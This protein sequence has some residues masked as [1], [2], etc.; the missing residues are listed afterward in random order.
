[1]RGSGVIPPVIGWGLVVL[2]HVSATIPSCVAQC[3]FVPAH[4][5]DV[6]RNLPSPLSNSGLPLATVQSLKFCMIVVCEFSLVFVLV[7]FIESVGD[8]SNAGCFKLAASLPWFGRC[9]SC[10]PA[11]L[12]AAAT[13]CAPPHWLNGTS[14]FATISFA[15]AS[16]IV[17][18]GACPFL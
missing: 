4:F 1:M 13:A 16:V 15:N 17:S 7:L 12:A 14:S 8:V 9:H 2:D 10:A 3:Y 18:T 6:V 5:C 11:R